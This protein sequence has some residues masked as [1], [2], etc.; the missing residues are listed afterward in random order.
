MTDF[1][2]MT[3]IFPPFFY[4]TYLTFL[5]FF[6]SRHSTS[7]L[8][9]SFIQQFF[10]DFSERWSLS[11][12]LC[13]GATSSPVV[14]VYFHG[15]V[16]VSK[17]DLSSDIQSLY[18]FACST[19]LLGFLADT[20]DSISSKLNLL[21]PRFPPSYQGGGICK[22]KQW[23]SFLCL[24]VSRRP[25]NHQ[26]T[27]ILPTWYLGNPSTSF[28]LHCHCHSLKSPPWSFLHHSDSLINSP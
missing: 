22:Q 4:A 6:H 25:V 17:R 23:R 20:L 9:H 16:I 3:T 2:W 12:S 10:A 14:L 13:S 15:V 26:I 7:S 27:P 5:L 28:F 19:S 8:L 1:I 18:S 24:F 21:M 11:Q